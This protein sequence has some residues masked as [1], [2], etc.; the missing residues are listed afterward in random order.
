LGGWNARSLAAVISEN[1]DGLLRG[2]LT[3]SIDLSAHSAD[4]LHA[5]RVG[6]PRPRVP[7]GVGTAIA[8]SALRRRLATVTEKAGLGA[9]HPTELRYSF[10]SLCL[11][12]DT[13]LEAT[14]DAAGHATTRM[15]ETTYRHP[16]RPTVGTTTRM[17]MDGLLTL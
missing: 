10:V 6:G 3:K 1:T 11:D 4:R 8:R 17:V 7:T 12:E 13:R 9:W 15:T 5:E 16:V 2:Y 14:R